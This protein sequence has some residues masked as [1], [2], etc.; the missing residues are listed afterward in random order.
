MKKTNE[1]LKDCP[2]CGCVDPSSDGDLINGCWVIECPECLGSMTG[3][4]EE[5][6]VT[7][8]NERINWPD[9]LNAAKEACDAYAECSLTNRLDIAMQNLKIEIEEL[10]D[11]L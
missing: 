7:K 3:S 10:N 9:L 6:A 8:W 11:E 1:N 4:D 5:S 2:F